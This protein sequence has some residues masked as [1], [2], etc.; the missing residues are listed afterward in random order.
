MDS[1]IFVVLDAVARLLLISIGL[2]VAWA[3]GYYYRDEEIERSRRKN[4]KRRNKLHY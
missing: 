4:R 1:S 2:V 3:F